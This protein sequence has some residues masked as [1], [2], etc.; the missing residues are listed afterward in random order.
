M[1]NTSR[2]M[3]FLPYRPFSLSLAAR[4]M[5]RAKNAGYKTLVNNTEKKFS[6]MLKI[7][8]PGSTKGV[9]ISKL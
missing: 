4:W 9:I 8:M 5:R 3:W 7:Y 2:Q 1:E 6:T